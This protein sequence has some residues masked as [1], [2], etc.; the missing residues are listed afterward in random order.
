MRSYIGTVR[1]RQG[2][3]ATSSAK[4]WS[5]PDSQRGRWSIH[6]DS[7][8]GR[9]R[10]PANVGSASGSPAANRLA[11]HSGDGAATISG[12]AVSGASC[13]SAIS[14][15]CSPYMC[16]SVPTGIGPRKGLLPS[17]RGRRTGGGMGRAHRRRGRAPRPLPAPHGRRRP[18]VAGGRARDLRRRGG[19]RHRT[20]AGFGPPGALAPP[21]RAAGPAPERSAG[22]AG[23]PRLHRVPGAPGHH[24]GLRR[25][26]GGTGHRRAPR[27]PDG[28]G[29]AARRP[30]AGGAGRAD[31]PREPRRHRP[32]RPRP[33]RRRAA[34]RPDVR[35]PALPA[36]RAGLDGGDPLPAVDTHLAV[37]GRPR[38]APAGRVHARRPD[39]GAGRHAH[40]RAR[41]LWTAGRRWPSCSAPR[42]PASRAA[43]LASCDLRVRI[44]LRTGVDSLNVGHAA[45]IAF[46]L[47]GRR[48]QA[49]R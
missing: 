22:R 43:A 45:A 34:A 6:D 13:T 29:R 28:R 46:H 31:G 44:P 4:T 47:L 36:S 40:R 35:R 12:P 21:A 10:S 1:W 33:R 41:R 7:S 30:P 19:D 42:G 23:R 20:A 18:P 26:P 15:A 48:G 2:R 9:R 49:P 39:P 37:A 3:R 32:E 27:R 14:N 25:S 38:P 16:S 17:S 5:D 11:C 24:D 8:S